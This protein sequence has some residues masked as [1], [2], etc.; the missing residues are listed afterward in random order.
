VQD[1][2]E[3]LAG[4]MDRIPDAQSVPAEHDEEKNM[5]TAT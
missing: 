1:F 2:F 4:Q 3:K 5:E